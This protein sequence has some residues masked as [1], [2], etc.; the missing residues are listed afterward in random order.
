M[1][2]PTLAA[3]ASSSTSTTLS[4]LAPLRLVLPPSRVALMFVASGAGLT[5]PTRMTETACV[6]SRRV[7]WPLDGH[8]ERRL[9]EVSVGAHL[10][11]DADGGGGRSAGEDGADEERD[12]PAQVAVGGQ[13][14][15]HAA[16][17]HP[18]PAEG[19]GAG[20]ADHAV[21]QREA[22]V[23]ACGLGGE[24]ELQ[25]DR[26]QDVDGERDHEGDDRH[27]LQQLLVPAV[28]ELRAR[29]V[30]DERHANVV[31]LRPGARVGA[32]LSR[33]TV[34]PTTGT[35]RVRGGGARERTCRTCCPRR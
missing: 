10:A 17:F 21:G 27:L 31:D 26:A 13:R 28:D 34:R 23:V 20:A 33:C 6:V 19:L 30:R 25:D 14:L 29:R 7:G 5:D 3:E 15:H 4:M 2:R 22:E 16:L 18:L 11:D 9:G 24:Q 1:V 12:G 8:A 35:W 32:G